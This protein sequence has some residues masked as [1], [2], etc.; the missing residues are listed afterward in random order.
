MT[1][2][3]RPPPGR[4]DD[5]HGRPTSRRRGELSELE[6]S[7]VG[8]AMNQ[9][10]AA[11]ARP[12]RTVLGEEVEIA[13]PE[14]RVLDAARG[15]RAAY[16]RPRHAHRRPFTFCGA[17]CRLV[18]LVP[19][20]FVVRMTRALDELAPRADAAAHRRPASDAGD[21]SLR[22]IP[23]AS[24]PSSAARACRSGR[25]VALPRR[26]RRRARPRGR[27]PRSTSTSTACA[28]RPAGSSSP[29]TATGPCGSSTCSASRGIH[30]PPPRLTP[31]PRRWQS[32]G[33]RARRR[34]RRVHAQD[35]LR[36]ADQGRPRGR[37]RGR[38]RRRGRR[39][40]TRSCAPTS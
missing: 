39:S 9:M 36:R 15:R 34:R 7:A 32:D 18:Q 29:T 25:V 38:Q 21:A 19:N 24:G 31:L 40:A 20:A 2:R 14:T 8:E 37:R 26:R 30:F 4:G 10:M 6:L 16:E 23:C 35:G 17:P 33:T 12:P 5:G 11:A 27:R 1:R 28:S 3:G 13:P 22:G